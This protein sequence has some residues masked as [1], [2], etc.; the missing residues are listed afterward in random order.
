VYEEERRPKSPKLIN[1]STDSDQVQKDDRSA[2]HELLNRSLAKVGHLDGG[3]RLRGNDR[4][5]QHNAEQG[6][7]V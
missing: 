2:T 1:L 5:Y 4:G 3:G 7:Q 6:A